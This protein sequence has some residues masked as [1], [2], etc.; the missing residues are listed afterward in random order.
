MTH[1][2][3]NAPA[4]YKPM[5]YEWA[6]QAW[7]TQQEVHWLAKEVPLADDVK[8]WKQ[9]LTDAERNLVTQ[10][11]RFFTQSDIEV[12]G[13]YAK[14][15]GVFKPTEILMMLAAFINIE[16]V[17]IEAYAYLLDTIGMPETEYSAFLKYAEMKEKHYYLQ[18]FQC[19]NKTN[20]AL[21]LAAF[22]AFAEGMA[23]FASFAMLLNFPRFNKMK[24]MGQLVSWS[25]RDECYAEGTEVL[26]S[27]GW[28]DF[29]DLKDE[30]KV[31]QYDMMTKEVS[32]VIPSR[33]V[34][35]D[36]DT[37]LVSLKTE[38]RID[39]L[40]T[41]AH[42]VVV[43]DERKKTTTR[44]QAEDFVPHA[45]RWFPV[46]GY[47]SSGDTI[48]TPLQRFRIAFS[49]DGTMPDSRHTGERH[50]YLRVTMTLKKER[51]KTRLRQIL[52]DGGIEYDE[53]PSPSKEN[54]S[55]FRV[56]APVDISKRLSSFIDLE[57]VSSEWGNAFFDEL[58]NW[59]GSDKYKDG[60][61]CVFGTTEKADMDIV[62]AI[63]TLCGKIA[64]PTLSI[65]PR[66]HK[67]YWR[68]HISGK[69]MIRTGRVD[70]ELVPY[71]GKVRCVTVP[72]GAVITRYNNKVVVSGNTLH[73]ES[74]AML[75]KTFLQENPEIDSPELRDQ[76][77]K[78]AREMV[79]HEFA[80]IDLAF[81][82]GPVQGL[83]AHQVKE[84]IQYIADRRL[85]RL[86][87]E[88]I[89]N[90]EENPLPW[91]DEMTT[92]VEH[93][94]FFENRSTEYSKAST[95]GDWGDVFG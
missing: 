50:G 12:A 43:H 90:V 27:R 37:D 35:Y 18:G 86:G 57:N 31:A 70:K 75:F 63:A 44:I 16:T 73:C 71:K 14:Y 82:M 69:D 47:K 55:I 65:D 25:I 32:F 67:D 9:N 45:T 13:T 77:V 15:L 91:F 42:G 36:V 3:L 4:I 85:V 93:A 58:V 46:S 59:D 8:D 5:K 2:L 89:Y 76:I 23:L 28:V 81:E 88:P 52:E 21:T 66:G 79:D 1:T 20:I 10:I 39:T 34:E 17:H 6:F 29:A 40:V 94:S 11:F 53:V 48:L 33:R 80:F 62:Q 92:A 72:T 26:T 49:A 61:T 24:G 95:E 56:N 41:K 74:M 60:S 84:F 7:K 19:D 30:D 83:D 64:N 38:S 87:L 78:I 68:L 51:K 54:T 22:G